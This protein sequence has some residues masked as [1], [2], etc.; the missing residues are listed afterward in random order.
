MTKVRG[1]YK[2]ILRIAHVRR[3]DDTDIM[4]TES[5][6]GS[7]AMPTIEAFLVNTV[8][9]LAISGIPL[10]ADGAH[11]YGHQC[12]LLVPATKAESACPVTNFKFSKAC[13]QI[14]RASLGRR[15]KE[16]ASPGCAQPAPPVSS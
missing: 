9:D 2:Q 6:V 10:S 8:L 15:C 3:Q 12:D 14:I 1:D 5:K 7:L 4:L 16:G 13:K 11:Q